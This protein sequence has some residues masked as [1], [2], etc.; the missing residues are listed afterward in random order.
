M[1]GSINR[2]WLWG[3]IALIASAIVQFAFP[4]DLS[5][6]QLISALLLSAA[7]MLFA[8]GGGMRRNIFG[9]DKVA[10]V[11]AV[12]L[13]ALMIAT[14]IISLTL[15]NGGPE[16]N[17]P[18][19][20]SLVGIARLTLTIVLAV[21]VGRSPILSSRWRW[22]PLWAVLAQLVSWVF[23]QFGLINA[24]NIAPELLPWVMSWAGVIAASV[25]IFIGV[26]AIL[27]AQHP[28]RPETDSDRL[29]QPS[30]RQLAR[31]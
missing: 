11:A 6:R 4:S 15:N 12:L 25:P 3:G 27:V 30:E 26:L 10:A 19:V 13:S 31:S 22:A 29:D 2:M 24:A 1:T 7:I 18:W 9:G 20:S 28:S 17:Q 14:S 23:W 8:F 5:A 16:W 21:Q